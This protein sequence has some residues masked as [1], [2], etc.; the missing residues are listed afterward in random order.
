M[1]TALYP[2]RVL[3]IGAESTK[4]TLVAATR[5]IVGDHVAGEEQDFYRSPYPTGVRA[6]TGGAGTIVRKGM[7]FDINTEL[8]PEEILWAFETG[9]KG[10]I[11]P[12]TV[13]TNAKLWTYTPELTTGVPTIKTATIEAVQSDGVTNHYYGEAGYC[14]CQ[15]FKMDWAFNQIAKLNMKFFGRARQSGTPTGS[16]TPYTGRESL[17]SNQLAVSW[18]TTYGGL[19]GT[20]FTGLVRSASLEVMTGYA[21][22]YVLDG[23]TDVDM[24][25]HKVGRCT[26]KLSIVCEFDATAA[27]KFALYRT[28]SIVY[29]RLR[30]NGSLI[31]A[32]SA[33]KYVNVDSGYRFTV[34]PQ[35]SADGDQILCS[36]ELESVNTAAEPMV[37]SAQNLLA[38][39]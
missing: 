7:S 30:N 4:G 28:N 2:F 33:L 27:A 6:N 5:Q 36:F 3:Q 21:P 37:L 14:M 32:V 22:D 13:D 12:S 10:G 35:F 19:G 38:A 18:D 23:R 8:T 11:S 31:G 16:L 29:I 39:I 25:L 34:Q 15:S 26:M 17:A 9:L 24:G 1:A 20:A